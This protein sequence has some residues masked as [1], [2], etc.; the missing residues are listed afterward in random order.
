MRQ[1]RNIIPKHKVILIIRDGWGY[2]KGKDQNAIA[3]TPT[4]NT[5]RLMKEY[6]W[7]LLQAHGEAVGQPKGYQGNSE[8][9]HMTMGSGRVIFQSLER[10]NRSIR[11]GEF[12]RNPELL[13]A[14]KNCKKHKSNLHLMG[15]LQT[16][17]V[18][19]H[20]DHLF[21]LLD[22]C[23]KQNFKDVYIHIFTDG[24]DAPVHESVKHM[25]VLLKKI[26][27][28]GFGKVATISGRYYA[29]D[30]NKNWDRTK[31]AYDCIVKA[32][33][34]EEFDNPLKMLERCHKRKETDEF[35]LPERAS[36]YKGVEAKDSMIF[37]NFRTDRPRQL[38]KAIVENKFEGWKRK[39]LDVYYVGMCQY[40]I[41]LN[42][43]VAFK[44]VEIKNILGEIVSRKGMRQLRISETE[45]YAHVTFFFNC[46]IEKPFRNEDRIMIQSSRVSTYDKTPEMKAKEIADRIVEAVNELGKGKDKCKGY[47]LI[48][49]NIVN[50]DMVG[51]T[52]NMPALKKAVSAVD[53]AVGRIVEAGLEKDYVI[54]ITADHGNAEDKTAKWRTSHTIN[55]VQFMLVSNDASLKNA[56]LKKGKGLCSI[57]P[58][59]L[60]V[61]G[62]QKPKDME[63]SALL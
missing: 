51:H 45:K 6:P 26:K 48:V 21:A 52:G 56:K 3:S 31:K 36:W 5:T 7:T 28:I 27:K 1:K 37:W 22:L 10:I 39:K 47:D 16:Q 53:K 19:G 50:G 14:I 61:M 59:V 60:K 34:K 46:Q 9:G 24:R 41:P 63:C 32:E 25:K 18:H 23:K 15:I 58:T 57:A 33:C 29:M 2:R 4:P 49:A 35:I 17:G 20:R 38:T 54:M 43:H 62:L 42:G 11:T 44:D 13:G 30:R 8:V 12:F 40:Y 55:P